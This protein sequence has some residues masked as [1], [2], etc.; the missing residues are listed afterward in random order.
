[1]K[2]KTRIKEIVGKVNSV[3][4]HETVLENAWDHFN[5]FVEAGVLF[6]ILVQ[7]KTYQYI[8]NICLWN[9]IVGR[10]KLLSQKFCQD[11]QEVIGQ[12]AVA[13]FF[14]TVCYSVQLCLYTGL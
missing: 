6:N 3:A 13:S 2:H 8:S 12:C 11:G 10:F 4:V 14:F 9:E 7:F 5:H 1:M